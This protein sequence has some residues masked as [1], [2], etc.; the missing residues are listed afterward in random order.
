MRSVAG[1]G[2][3]RFVVSVMVAEGHPDAAVYSEVHGGVI[4]L[5]LSRGKSVD[6]FVID[7]NN[8]APAKVMTEISCQL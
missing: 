5:D 4:T 7:L 8:D 1:D 2:R 6:R 3:T